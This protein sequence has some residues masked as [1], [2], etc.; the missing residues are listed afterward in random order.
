MPS[1]NTISLIAMAIAV[2]F[3][4]GNV[5]YTRRTFAVAFK[6]EIKPKFELDSYASSEYTPT[7]LTR[8]RSRCTFSN[9][10]N[11]I[12]ITDLKISFSFKAYISGVSGS[13][14]AAKVYFNSLIESLAPAK[15]QIVGQLIDDQKQN[16]IE[17]LA[18]EYPTIIKFTKA[19]HFDFSYYQI[20]SPIVLELI[21]AYSYTAALHGAR[22]VSAVK[23]NRFMA[24]TQ[25]GPDSVPMLTGWK[26]IEPTE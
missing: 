22:R 5:W 23:V 25:P 26:I 15:S 14:T 13:R 7:F 12:T 2:V 16:I 19:A 8:S 24:I 20:P 21:T 3:G 17:F 10:S 6:P 4:F 11:T 9:L 18:A 1:S